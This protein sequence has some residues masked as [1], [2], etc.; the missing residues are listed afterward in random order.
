MSQSI[1]KL[2]YLNLVGEIN[3]REEIGVEI[4][5]IER[6]IRRR[7]IRIVIGN[8]GDIDQGQSLKDVNEG[9]S[10]GHLQGRQGDIDPDPE[11]VLDLETE[12]IE[13]IYLKLNFN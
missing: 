11:L 1:L 4:N 6:E 7:G 13:G 2:A 12:D 3:Q 8:Q 9:Q 5:I 10:Q